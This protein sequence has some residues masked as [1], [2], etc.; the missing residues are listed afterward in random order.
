MKNLWI[1][2]QLFFV[3]FILLFTFILT[4]NIVLRFNH[5]WDFTEQKEFSLAE[6][7]IQLLKELENSPIEVL[8]FYPQSDDGRKEFEVFLKEMNL[9]HPHFKYTFYDPDRV[10]QLAK[11]YQ[12]NDLYTVVIRYRDVIE[13]VIRPTEESFTNALLRLAKP[14]E[15]NICFVTGHGEA[16]IENSEPTGYLSFDKALKYN[17]YKTHEI[18]LLRDKI[19]SVCEVVMVAGPHR[20]FDPQEYKILSEALEDGK[21]VFFLIDPMDEGMGA[22]FQEFFKK[23]GVY[24]GSDVIVDKMS[25]MVGGDFLIPLVTHYVGAHQITNNFKLATF[26]PV[27]RSIQPSTEETLGLEITPLAFTSSGSWAEGDLKSLEQGEAAFHA[28]TDLSGP[29]VIAVAVE[30]EGDAHQDRGRMVVLGDSDFLSNAYLDLS[31]NRDFGFNVINWLT[32]DDR[33]VVIKPRFAEFTPLYLT[34]SQ[35]TFIFIFS[36]LMLPGFFF[37]TG[38]FILWRRNRSL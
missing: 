13:R 21:S 37:V 1:R 9:H 25:R 4:Y 8:G 38:A 36:L 18:I 33:R 29:I 27:A 32:K 19:P 16:Q 28:S 30:G 3:S 15:W 20:D 6:P 17:H 5:R 34:P 12:I 26:F 7:T 23:F 11:K 2:L 14:R 24:V 22:S 35:Q 10:P 31:G